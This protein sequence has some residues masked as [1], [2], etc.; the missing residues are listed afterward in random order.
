MRTKGLIIALLV[1]WSETKAQSA[2]SALSFQ[3]DAP[4]KSVWTDSLGS[5]HLKDNFLVFSAGL[6]GGDYP[7]ACFGL[8]LSHKADAE[9]NSFIGLGAHY[10][11][12]T[13]N[14]E[15]GLLREE[16]VQIVPV[17][18]DYR[19]AIKR[20]GNGKFSTFLFLDA[21]YVF[22]ITGNEVDDTGEYEYKNGWGINPG[23]SFKFDIF[24]NAGLMLDLGWLR[25]TSR[26]KWLPPSDKTGKKKWDLGI[27]RLSAFF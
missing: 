16:F 18:A 23:I 8:T 24:K 10:I 9:G 7:L 13:I 27:V 12:N 4:A 5:H 14:T 19:Q 21:G 25:H 3:P 22:S 17:M 11:S 6:G 20:S 15:N 26:L 1:I 2:M